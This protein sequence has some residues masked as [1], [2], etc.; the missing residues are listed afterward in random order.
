M[1]QIPTGT[2][3][4]PNSS[5]VAGSEGAD[6]SSDR[7][8]EWIFRRGAVG[9]SADTCIVGIGWSSYNLAKNRVNNF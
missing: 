2:T 3:Y 6:F 7:S 9:R 5:R 8:Q 1:L 4:K